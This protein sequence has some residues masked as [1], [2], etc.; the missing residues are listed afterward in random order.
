[1]DSL[2]GGHPGV[3]FILSA[4][5]KSVE[6][7]INAF[8]QGS[9]YKD[10]WFGEY[11]LVDTINK[12]DIDNGKI[13]RRGLDYQNAVGGA[14]YI[15]Q[16]VG[17]SGP[18][19]YFQID[20]LEETKERAEIEAD[21]ELVWKTY[22]TGRSEDGKYTL[23]YNGNGQDI[24]EF[25]FDTSNVLVPG[26]VDEDVFNDSIKYTWVNIRDNTNAADSWFYVGFKIPYTVIEYGIHSVSPYDE[27]GNRK[28]QADIE[29]KD[30]QQHP[31]YEFWELGVPKGIKGDVLRNLRVII[32]TQEDVIYSI[33][34]ITVEKN[35]K[36]GQYTSK[37]GKAGYDGQQEDI[38]GKRKILVFDYTVYDETE[39]GTTV[40]VYLG[41]FNLIDAVKLDEEG[42][43]TFEFSHDD[44]GIFEKKIRWI[45]LIELTEGTG[46]Q[47]GHITFTWNNDSPQDKTEFDISWLKVLEILENG[48]IRY[49]FAGTPEISELPRG[50]ESIEDGVYE[51]KNFLTWIQGADFSN[52]TGKLTFKNNRGE[53]VYE[54]TVSIINS[55]IIDSEGHITFYTTTDAEIPV[56][57]KD[58]ENPFIVK[59]IEDIKL[60]NDLRE[61]HHIQIKTNVDED[62]VSIGDPINFIED[63]VI[64]PSNFHL[65]V[66]FSDPEHRVTAEDLDEDGYDTYGNQWYNNIQNSKGINLGE[67]IYWRDYGAVKDQSGILVGFNILQ[68][69]VLDAGFT[70]VLEYLNNKYPNGL[71]EE[72]NKPGYPPLVGKIITWSE[73]DEDSKQFYGYDYN[74]ETWYYLGEVE[75]NTAMRD[76][77]LLNHTV[78]TTEDAI[79]EL[80]RWIPSNG[81]LIEG[82]NFNYNNEAI[83]VYWEPGYTAWT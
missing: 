8:K 44:D 6:E 33:D 66:L 9:D 5:Y 64:L 41:D 37:F 79:K 16:I 48:T 68:Q 18:T 42:T 57:D 54:T 22:P 59:T 24:A 52:E 12:Q 28:D 25:E 60:S 43:L 21:G 29:R 40:M 27:L 50:I 32:P 36:T 78:V 73:G 51:L 71:T 1:M 23:E 67:D 56:L 62:Y 3:S 61:D 81:V 80:K 17:P 30:T 31:F 10:V 47:G 11:C 46:T 19:P 82:D 53:V 74:L 38:N 75:P 70:D 39:Q 63:I 14:E 69:E 2:Y 20:T 58:G 76:V 26:K 15:G 35:E 7:M 4:S 72:Q 34:N 49:T 55:A 45:D 13:Y 65:L 77:R 83:P